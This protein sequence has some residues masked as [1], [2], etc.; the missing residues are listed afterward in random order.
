MIN[1]TTHLE[2][3]RI[4]GFVF[5]ERHL[6]MLSPC[7]R[8]LSYWQAHSPCLSLIDSR[9]NASHPKANS[10]THHGLDHSID[11]VM[12]GRPNH[13]PHPWSQVFCSASLCT[14]ALIPAQ[15]FTR[16]SLSSYQ[17]STGGVILIFHPAHTSYY[18]EEEAFHQSGNDY[19]IADLMFCF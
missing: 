12:R 5:T 15:A 8:V 18:I 11:L 1:P 14:L 2:Y 17:G 4:A 10:T 6:L 9:A 16:Q 13:Q 7:S 19:Q 3:Q